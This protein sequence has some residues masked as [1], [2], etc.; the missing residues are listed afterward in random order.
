MQDF[1]LGILLFLVYYCG[2][3]C[4]RYKSALGTTHSE[5]TTTTLDAT[6]TPDT[7]PSLQIHSSITP[8]HQASNPER[9][10]NNLSSFN[11]ETESLDSEATTDLAQEAPTDAQIPIDNTLHPVATLSLIKDLKLK[12]ARKVASLLGIQQQVNGVKKPKEFLQR[13]IC[14]TFKVSPERVTNVVK[15]AVARTFNTD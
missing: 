7:N 8:F 12:E 3:S 11:P 4:F 1:L 10:I 6:Q 9:H 14:Q 2:A 15:E 13:E 5:T